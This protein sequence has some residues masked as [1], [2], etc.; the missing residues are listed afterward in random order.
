MTSR[1][2]R[3]AA[4]VAVSVTVA[5]AGILAVG[6]AASA[7]ELPGSAHSGLVRV[8]DG[9]VGE[10]VHGG[11]IGHDRGYD[12]HRAWVLD[13]VRWAHDHGLLVQGR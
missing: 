7:A 6:G 13:Q 4:G 10:A 11:R 12:V 5:M 8:S 3:R 2:A 1:I 9:R